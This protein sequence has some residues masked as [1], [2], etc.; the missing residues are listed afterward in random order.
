MPT[1]NDILDYLTEKDVLRGVELDIEHIEAVLNV[2]VWDGEIE[3]LWI[4]R[5]QE[6]GPAANYDF[7]DLA[8]GFR[9][10]V[11]RR[12]AGEANGQVRKKR[13]ARSDSGAIDEESEDAAGSEDIPVPGTKQE[14]DVESDEGIRRAEQSADEDYLPPPLRQR[15]E[16]GGR[17][18]ANHRRPGP[19]NKEW[20]W[21]YRTSLTAIASGQHTS[22]NGSIVPVYPHLYELG[23]TQTPCGICPVAEFCQNRG[24]P[25]VLPLPGEK[26]LLSK[27][28]SLAGDAGVV[29]LNDIAGKSSKTIRKRYDDLLKMKV[30]SGGGELE[31]A[32]GKWKGS[33]KV[34]GTVVAPVNPAGCELNFSFL[35]H[36]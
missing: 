1:A 17:Q 18:A 35:G 31:D 27:Q 7:D 3:R 14:S 12:V 16:N 25:K 5:Y 13:R 32:D 26:D 4:R 36:L 24:Q 10:G 23:L 9:A 21:V 30:P 11:K 8:N 6:D 2:L 22:A 15:H 20:Y 28:P 19:Q 33:V 34:G 29:S